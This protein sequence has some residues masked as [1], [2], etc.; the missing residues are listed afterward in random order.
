MTATDSRYHS[1][2]EA[3]RH[4]ALLA[5]FLGCGFL[6]EG[7]AQ[8]DD[9]YPNTR[10]R[11]RAAIEYEDEEIHV[12]ASYNYSQRHHDSP[13][14]LI[15]AAV[16]DERVMDIQRDD[17]HLVMPDGRELPLASQE[18]FVQEM[19]RIRRLLQNA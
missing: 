15:K 18:R 13:W 5:L 4:L 3:R 11:G 1:V 10:E 7:T 17:I 2:F 19:W 9:F 8:E 16:S 12:V 14:L 6:G